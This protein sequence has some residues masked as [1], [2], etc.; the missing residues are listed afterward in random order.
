MASVPL[1]DG[2]AA[3]ASRYDGF[4]CDLWGVL[5][6]GVTAFPAA[7]DCL[8]HLRTAGKQV[9]ILS[10][11]PRRAGEV[12]DSAARL[13]ILPELHCGVVSSGEA[14][15]Q[16]LRHRPDAF[17]KSLGTR[18]YHLGPDRDHGMRE[19][20]DLEFVEDI[21]AADFL[22]NTGAHMAKDT[23]EVYA[24]ELEAGAARELP[25]VC[26]NPDLEV[27]R[28]GRR[29]I[30]AGALARTY[31]E[32]G[33]EVRYHGKPHADIYEACFVALEGIA[34]DRILAVGDSLRTDIVGGQAA[35]ID[36]LFIAGG[37]HAESLDL[38]GSDASDG[39]LLNTLFAAQDTTPSAAMR[40]FVW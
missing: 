34:R 18:C 7:I 5:H 6:D 10:N 36:S 19:G 29:E 16:H 24:G 14:A 39:A 2:L 33:G 26:A 27:I 13:G 37:I 35:G 4:I 28:G 23:P 15:W 22:L 9:V 21:A 3:L 32:L 17:Y 25:M 12:R 38:H 30:C 40:S 1:Y 20:L 11:A 31:E 8:Q